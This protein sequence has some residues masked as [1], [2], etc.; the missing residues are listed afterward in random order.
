VVD[1]PAFA[2]A[3]LTGGASRR[4]G[5][6]KATLAIDGIAM[7]RRVG[8]AAA[9]AGADRVVAVGLAVDGLDHLADEHPG[10]GPLGAVVTAL[11]W[12]GPDPVVVLACDLLQP[13]PAAVAQAIAVL[14]DDPAAAVAVPVVDGR[15]QWLHAAWRPQAA[16]GALETAF[17]AGERSIH[18][19]VSSLVVARYE[20][21]DP[22]AFGDADT[23][24]DLP[25][26]AR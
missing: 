10:A 23:I 13:S 11:R 15:A 5:R 9:A 20:E 3:V 17:A 8:A 7:A 19:A 4:M 22:V 25:P 14:V 21:A 6:A 26:G 2:A 16:L 12:A 18:G 24:A 1:R